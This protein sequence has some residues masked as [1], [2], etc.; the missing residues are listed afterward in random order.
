MTVMT[1]SSARERLA[2]AAFDLFGEC[3][4]DQTTVDDITERAGLSRTTFFRHCR[5]KEDVIFPDHDLLLQQVGERL[6]TSSQA[7]ALAA[8]SDAVRLSCCLH[9]RG[10]L[11]PLALRADQR[12]PGASG[13]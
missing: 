1:R 5:S 11:G 4:Y 8:V 10:R 13:P 7:T 6:R 2:D 3:G 9:R 12:R